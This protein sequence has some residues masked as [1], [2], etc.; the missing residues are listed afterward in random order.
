MPINNASK[1]KGDIRV[2]LLDKKNGRLSFKVQASAGLRKY[3]L[4]DTF[5]V[6]YDKNIEDI[7]ESILSIPVTANLAPVSWAAGADLHV[8]ELDGTFLEALGAIKNT[9]KSMFPGFSFGGNIHVDKVVWNEFGHKG[10]AQ[11]FSSGIDSVAT[12]ARHRD[13]KPA[14]LYLG[15]IQLFDEKLERMVFNEASAFAQKEGVALHRI[16]SNT[17][18]TFL[19]HK[20][21]LA[22]FDEC[23]YGDS[24]WAGAQH[25][26]GLLGICAPLTAICDIN[27]IYIASTATKDPAQGLGIPWGSHPLIDNN[28]AW[29]GVKGVHDG[30]EWSRQEKIRHAIKPYMESTKSYPRLIVCNDYAR[31]SVLNC[32]RCEKC[33][34]TII[35]LAMEGIDPNLCG[36]KVDDRTFDNIKR[37][38]RLRPLRYTHRTSGMWRD[39]QN[40]IPETPTADMYGS[41]AF[42]EW[43]RTFEV[44]EDGGK[45]RT[46]T[47][48]MLQKC[49]KLGIIP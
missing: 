18:Y 22:D 25:G 12:F 38:L 6:K 26:L 7:G 39:L 42:L 45:N 44:R 4:A 1:P 41:K 35:G 19:N 16:E 47:Q 24:W 10:A 37:R 23:L 14:L 2:E 29:A 5:Y 28:I 34:K 40:A 3:F 27:K 15:I 9:M 30:A 36:F 13:E 49:L 17:H 33:C 31:G 11:L 48:R 20:S 43:F 21:L 8:K 32:G 46:L